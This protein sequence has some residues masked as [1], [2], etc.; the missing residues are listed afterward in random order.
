MKTRKDDNNMDNNINYSKVLETVE[1]LTYQH[2]FSDDG[3]QFF[4]GKMDGYMFLTTDNAAPFISDECECM[5]VCAVGSGKLAHRE[6][7]AIAKIAADVLA[8]FMT[9]TYNRYGKKIANS[10]N[11]APYIWA[12]K[13]IKGDERY[14]YTE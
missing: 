12:T 4:W 13:T 9:G 1:R 7:E 11:T 5:F 2:R 8:E 14:A 6:R 3:M 10:A